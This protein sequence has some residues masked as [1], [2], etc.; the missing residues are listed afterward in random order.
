M[1][2]WRCLALR[3]RSRVLLRSYRMRLRR[4]RALG[5]SYLMRLRLRR[6]LALRWR[7]RVRL[8]LRHDRMLFW[9]RRDR[10]LLRGRSRLIVYLQ[11]RRRLHVVICWKR[12]A[13]N[14]CGRATM[15]DCRKLRLVGACSVLVLNLRRHGR[16]V[17]R[18]QRY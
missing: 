12:L 2:W 15:V 6:R 1:R 9:L 11:R 18:A 4:R 7:H 16:N 5:R 14:H 3:W 17:R 8:L 10:M 13:G